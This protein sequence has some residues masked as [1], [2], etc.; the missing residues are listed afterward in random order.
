MKRI[1]YFDRNP[2]GKGWLA[3]LN[4]KPGEIVLVN[5]STYRYSTERMGE[6]FVLTPVQAPRGK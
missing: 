6:D 1:N 2:N 5:G 4:L 3:G